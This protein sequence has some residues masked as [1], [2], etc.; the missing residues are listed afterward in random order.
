MLFL[1]GNDLASYIYVS[2]HSLKSTFICFFPKPGEIG[3]AGT[4]TGTW[5]SGSLSDLYIVE[6]FV[7]RLGQ[8]LKHL[9]LA[10][11][12]FF[13]SYLKVL[14][15]ICFTIEQSV[16]YCCFSLL[17]IFCLPGKVTGLIMVNA[18]PYVSILG[19]KEL[20]KSSTNRY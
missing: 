16:W 12:S 14:I 3:V 4:F 7:S 8:E 20:C 2:L 6:Y 11:S 5:K 19:N 18:W 9:T 17:F 10:F 1:A 15:L 13:S